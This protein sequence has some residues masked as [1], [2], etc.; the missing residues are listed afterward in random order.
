MYNFIRGITYVQYVHY[1]IWI[2]NKTEESQLTNTSQNQLFKYYNTIVK[3]IISL[4]ICFVYELGKEMGEFYTKYSKKKG[5]IKHSKVLTKPWFEKF[6][7]TSACPNKLLVN[8]WTFF[9][10]L[11]IF[12]MCF[13][14]CLVS[15]LFSFAITFDSS[16][17]C[18]QIKF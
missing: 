18:L 15:S 16:S 3:N 17:F 8:I 4:T 13:S 6:E 7:Y 10:K 5:K 12:S 2:I 9:S 14:F 1:V 11:L